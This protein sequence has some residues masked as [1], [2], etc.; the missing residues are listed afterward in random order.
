MATRQLNNMA[1]LGIGVIDP[2]ITP[3]KRQSGPGMH[4]L[5]SNVNAPCLSSCGETVQSGMPSTRLN[6][7]RALSPMHRAT[8][9]TLCAPMVRVTAKPA[10]DPGLPDASPIAIVAGGGVSVGVP[11]AVCV[12]VAPD[13]P[14]AVAVLTGVSVDVA[15]TVVGVDVAVALTGGV[16][17]TVALAVGVPLAPG[18]AVAVSIGVAVAVDIEVFVAVAVCGGVFVA[19]GVEAG[20]FVAV[21]EA[22]GVLVAVWDDVAVGVSRAVAVSVA[23]AVCVAVSVGMGVT[24]GVSLGVCVAV[25]AAVPVGVA[26]WLGVAVGS[27][28]WPSQPP[29]QV[30]PASKSSSG[31]PA[32]WQNWAQSGALARPS[33]QNPQLKHAQHCAAARVDTPIASAAIIVSQTSWLVIQRAPR[34]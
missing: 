12:A 11:L 30:P 18:V 28:G 21:A 29:S 14:V 9:A 10:V 5:G 6:G 34:A 33:T 13:V 23:L 26:V 31:Q 1:P 4:P 7:V 17:V 32:S 19:V 16:V 25:A 2:L 20:V 24:V 22:S 15:T 27:S 8:P 3:H